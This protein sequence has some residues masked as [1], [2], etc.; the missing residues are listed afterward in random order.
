MSKHTQVILLAH[1]S[2]R[3]A[4]R[5]PFEALAARLGPSTRMAYLELCPPTLVEAATAAAAAGITH[6]AVLPVFWSSGGHVARD[7]PGHV[8]AARAV[9]GIESIEVLTAVG[10]H[11]RI[12]EALGAIV[13]EIT[14][15]E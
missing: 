13:G 6:I 5:A 12:I 11:P 10:E 9:P 8:E 2:S 3:A 7:V 4:W 15:P 1:G 14:E